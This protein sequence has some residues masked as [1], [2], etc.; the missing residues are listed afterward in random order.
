MGE[1]GFTPLSQLNPSKQRCRVRVRISRLWVSF[2]PNNGTAFGLDSLLVDDE[3]GTMQAHVH[4][5]YKKFFEGR[6]VKGKVYTLSGF[7]V[8]VSEGNYMTCRNRFMMHIGPQTVVDE[9]DG[10]VGSIP[11]HSF[12]FVDFGDVPSRNCDNSLLTD[13]IGQVVEV[14]PVQE[15]RKKLRVIPICSLWIK[16]FSGKEQEV[17]LY[18]ELANDFYAEIREKCRLGLVVAVFAGMCVR[19]Y[20]GKGYIVCSSPPSKYYLDLEIP[21]AQ[22]FR[23]NCHH[24]KIAIVHPQSQQESPAG[25]TEES[26]GISK[27]TQE[28][29]S[30]WRTVKQLESLDP[31]ELPEN[32]RFLCKV[33]LVKIDCTK[34]WCYQ[35][36][37]HCRRSI[38]GDGSEMWCN[39]CDSVN[40]KRK[41]PVWWYK[42]DAVVEDATGTMN[43]MIFSDEAQGLIG[44][45][46]EDLVDE[47]TDENRRTMPDAIKNLIGSTHAFQ[48][49]ID[50]RSLGFVV[51]WVLDDDA[52]MLLQHIGS[53]QVTVGGGDSP[54]PEEEGSSSASSCSS[55][56][57][58]VGH[59]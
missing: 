28:L 37:F 13:V 30:S 19:H 58:E 46:A 35:G 7:V 31:F 5:V 44:V 16:D 1:A 29:Q 57:T 41:R 51:K 11:L 43:L 27:L 4:P 9:I 49:A 45:A 52:L 24:P 17:T 3:G 50:H 26:Q 53:S 14:R 33:S 34:G 12:D 21:E 8:G 47:I 48:V 42:L 6:L 2:N 38:S 54:L 18:G 55:Q 39:R 56:L 32:A 59:A 25:P 36:C 40:K 10:D 22:E 23:M 15:V 20:M